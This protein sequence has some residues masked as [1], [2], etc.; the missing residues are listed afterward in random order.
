MAINYTQ[1]FSDHYNWSFMV[2][3]FFTDSLYKQARSEKKFLQVESNLLVSRNLANVT[4]RFQPFISAGIGVTSVK[5]YF[6]GFI[7]FGAGLQTHLTKEIY[8]TINAQYRLR[9]SSPLP[10]HLFYSLGLAATINRKERREKKSPAI[11]LKSHANIT[12]NIQADKDHD[13]II[14]SEDDCPDRPGFTNKKGCPD[15][16]IN[17]NKNHELPIVVNKVKYS[18]SSKD[19]LES[20]LNKLAKKILFETNSYKIKS[21][22]FRSLNSIY[23]LFLDHPG[24]KVTVEGHTDGVGSAQSNQ[25]L[26]QKRSESVSSYLRSKGI[27]DARLKSIGYGET[28][29]LSDDSTEKGR[30]ANRRVEFKIVEKS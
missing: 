1:D 30:A 7:P 28:V 4:S 23:Q 12:P 24:I 29:P 9:L 18:P 11:I 10:S 25:I 17:S 15:I 26:S 13:G 21:T 3:G 2:A 6:G 19:S 22:S 27:D 20:T 14:D 8:S 16:A 5:R